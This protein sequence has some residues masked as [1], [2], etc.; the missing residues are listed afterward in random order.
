[1]FER[2]LLRSRRCTCRRESSDRP[3]SAHSRRL[4]EARDGQNETS[5][6][7]G[8]SPTI[9][10]AFL[11]HL[12]VICWKPSGR[13]GGILGESAVHA[14]RAIPDDIRAVDY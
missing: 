8:N 11:L 2:I 9:I 10:I 1:M 12:N 14:L 7:C 3:K 4:G 6:R 5:C 13:A